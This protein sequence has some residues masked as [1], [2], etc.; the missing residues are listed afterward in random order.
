[1]VLFLVDFYGNHIRDTLHH[2]GKKVCPTDEIS[3][4]MI[5]RPAV[6]L[7]R[8]SQLLDPSL[9]H[10]HDPIT[11]CHRL[12]LVMGHIDAGDP[13][14]LLDSPDLSPHLVSQ[15]CIKVGKWFIKEQ[16]TRFGD[17]CPCKCH[18]LL[19]TTGKLAGL[20]CPEGRKPHGSHD[21]IHFALDLAL[22]Q[23]LQF[24]AEADILLNREVGKDGIGLEHHRRVAFVCRQI[25]Y[26][27]TVNV[28]ITLGLFL[29]PADDSQRGGL[30][31]AG[32]AEEGNHL[33]FLYL[34]IDI[35]DCCEL[36]ALVILVGENLGYFY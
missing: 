24:K 28:D 11:D 29:K 30:A 27:R 17:D 4:K 6:D 10:D 21:H 13:K 34:N 25:I 35:I 36:L 3:D 1:M 14:L 2:T 20:P 7:K 33:P 18:T 15:L 26:Q 9:V 31:A 22:L 5:G 12:I 19:L 32:W 23:P 8:S 16:H